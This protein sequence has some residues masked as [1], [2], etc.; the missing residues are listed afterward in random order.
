MKEFSLSVGM[1]VPAE[2]A[3]DDVIDKM[4]Q[5]LVKIAESI[6]N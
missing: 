2:K 6:I 1:R 4:E 3:T 5:E